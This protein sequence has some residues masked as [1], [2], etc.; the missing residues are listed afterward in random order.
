MKKSTIYTTALTLLLAG[1]SRDVSSDMPLA[2]AEPLHFSSANPATRTTVDTDAERNLRIVWAAGDEVGI[3][4][5]SDGR[6]TGRN[7]AY[8]ATPCKEDAAR[9]T[10]AASESSQLFR[11]IDGTAQGYYAYYPYTGVNDREPDAAAH[12]FSLPERQ[13]QSQG[14][15]PT[16][17]S[18]YGLMTAAPVEFGPTDMSQGGVEFR[19]AN[20]FSI[21]ELRFKMASDCSLA[22]VPVKQVRI[23]SDAS[24]LAIPQGTIDLTDAAMPLTVEEGSRSID[25][26]FTENL[27]LNKERFV[28]VYL[29]VA[30][31]THPAGS[32]RIE[33]TAIDNSVNSF[34][35][36]DAVTFRPNKHYTREYAISLDEFVQA[37]PFEVELPSLSCRAGEPLRIDLSG[38]AD[39]IDF[40]S[41]E[42][43]HDYLYAERDRLQHPAMSVDFLML[44]NSGTQRTPVKVK[45][46][47]DFDGTMTEEGILAATWNDVTAQFDLTTYIYGTDTKTTVGAST[48]PHNAGTADCSDWFAGAENSCHIALFYHIDPYDASYVDPE[49]GTAGNGRTYFYLHDMWVRAQYRNESGFTEIYR[50]QYVKNQTDPTWPTVVLGATFGSEDGGNPLNVYAYGSY[51]YVLRL[52]AAFRPTVEKNSYI[53]LPRLIRPEAKNV[54]RDTPFT[55]KE[56]SEAQPASYEYVFSRPGTYDIAVVGTV[57]TLS[58][59]SQIVKQATV[60]VTEE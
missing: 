12:P 13:V 33:L 37:D 52:G 36:P 42:E 27:S 10:F 6:P 56:E 46:S 3:Y 22:A 51:P 29:V 4:G 50:H 49:T 44:L 57:Q 43:G 5:M 24:D 58:G 35:V 30:P 2:D 48:T 54:G 28:S 55:I 47:T 14:D 17:L 19:F 45:Y 39:R 21:L 9:C 40:W 32:L 26:G 15:S 38:L 31:G 20:V 16:H 11:W 59:S 1:C 25:V 60:T 18:Q 41:G 34:T 8:T 7:Y 23:V 53:V